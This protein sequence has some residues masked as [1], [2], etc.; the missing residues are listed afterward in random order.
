MIKLVIAPL[1]MVYIFH[2]LFILQEYVQML[3]LLNAELLKQG[4]RYH[5]IRKAF[6]NT[7]TQSHLL[8]TILV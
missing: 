7:D 5:K 8:N 2:N 4:N 3:V 6:A 1:P